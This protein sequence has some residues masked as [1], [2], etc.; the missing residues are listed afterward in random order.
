MMLNLLYERYGARGYLICSAAGRCERRRLNVKV[1]SC[2]FSNKNEHYSIHPN[3]QAQGQHVT[4][5]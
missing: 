3:R 2:V 1:P 5:P 4:L